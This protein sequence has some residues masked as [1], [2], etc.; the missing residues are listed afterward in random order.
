[1]PFKRADFRDPDQTLSAA[2]WALPKGHASSFQGAAQVVTVGCL[3]SVIH[4][5]CA[6]RG[7]ASS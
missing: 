2:Q 7:F 5:H 3:R 4:A 1:M 6:A